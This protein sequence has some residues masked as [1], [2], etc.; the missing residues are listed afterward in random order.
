V[1]SQPIREYLCKFETEFESISG[2]NL[3]R[4][5][6]TVSHTASFSPEIFASKVVKIGFS[7]VKDTAET[8]DEV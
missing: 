3:C 2:F 4:L 7:D 1:R 8:K 6:K 5:A